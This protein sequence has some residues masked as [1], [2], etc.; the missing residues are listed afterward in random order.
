MKVAPCTAICNE[1]G[2]SKKGTVN[3]LYAEAFDI[4]QTGK[5]FPCHLYLKQQTGSESYG[6]ELLNEIKVCR[7]YV[8]FMKKHHQDTI[9]SWD[10]KL[11]QFW[12]ENLLSCITEKDMQDIYT[13]EEL[14]QAHK[15]LAEYIKLNNPIGGQNYG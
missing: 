9:N 7:G 14:I 2:F 5:I 15:G 1:C 12:Q 8:A 13:P 4:I 11:Q 3:T 10:E 6:T